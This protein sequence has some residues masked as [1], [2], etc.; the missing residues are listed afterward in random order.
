M[1]LFNSLAAG[2][3][4]ITTQIRAAKDYLTEPE[5]CLWV[6]PNSTK[7]LQAAIAKLLSNP[8]LM[9]E[10]KYRNKE[11]S[12]LFTRRVVCKELSQTLNLCCQ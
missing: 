7:S 11:K 5:N 9:A 12:N 6:E 10:M 8:T 2:L 1:V 3:P 4:I